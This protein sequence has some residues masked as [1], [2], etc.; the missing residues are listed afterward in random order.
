MPDKLCKFTHYWHP[1]STDLL[2]EEAMGLENG[3]EIGDKAAIKFWLMQLVAIVL[4][5]IVIVNV[6]MKLC[7]RSKKIKKS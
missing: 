2:D 5:S 3:T 4:G 1:D 6:I 7:N